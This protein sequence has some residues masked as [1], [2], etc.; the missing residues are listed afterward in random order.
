[1]HGIHVAQ[2][3][4]VIA[5][6]QV[7]VDHVVPSG[8]GAG[9]VK[10]GR[11]D[12]NIGHQPGRITDV[13]CG[14]TQKVGRVFNH[15]CGD[16][17]GQGV[18]AALGHP[19]VGDF[20]GGVESIHLH[21]ML[22]V[23]HANHHPTGVQALFERRRQFAGQPAIAFGPGEH[24]FA[25]APITP[26]VLARRVK[27]VAA[28]EVV[29]ARPGRHGGDACAVVVAATVV[30]VPAQVRVAQSVL[31]KVSIKSDSEQMSIGGDF[32]YF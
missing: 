24:A 19:A 4:T 21:A 6:G 7:A 5:V 17:H 26:A 2:T 20:S 27:A 12:V 31:P 29:N 15:S 23:G 28:G 22:G 13:H 8:R 30:Q 9:P 3:A 25:F 18:Y 1:M 16:E 11:A 14:G 10:Q 32:R